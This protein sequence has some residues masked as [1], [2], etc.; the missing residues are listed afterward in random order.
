MAGALNR[1]FEGAV[2]MQGFDCG[3]EIAVG[4]LAL[5]QGAAPELPLLFC[6]AAE[7]EDHRKGD[8]S[9]PEI[10]ADILAE[11]GRCSAIVE[12]IIDQLEGNSEIDPVAA[13]SCNLCL[14][15]AA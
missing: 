3:L 6:A 9:F 15:L 13:A 14:G 1:V 4:D 12:R 2:L 5:F 10:I 7:C 11:F 8:L